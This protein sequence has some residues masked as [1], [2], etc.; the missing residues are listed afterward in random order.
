MSCM[1]VSKEIMQERSVTGKEMSC[2]K[3]SKEIMQERGRVPG[4]LS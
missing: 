2:L 3:F 1:Q 4:W